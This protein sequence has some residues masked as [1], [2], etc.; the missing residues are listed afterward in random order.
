[1]WRGT[2]RRR[3]GSHDI[4]QSS[5]GIKQIPLS[6]GYSQPDKEA[7][8]AQ[9]E[10]Q[11]CFLAL[12]ASRVYVNQVYF[13]YLCIF[14]YTHTYIHAYVQIY[15]Y[16]DIFWGWG[17]VGVC[18][19]LLLNSSFAAVQQ[20]ESRGSA[21]QLQQMQHLLKVLLAEAMWR[22]YSPPQVAFTL[23]YPQ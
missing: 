14:V 13:T 22:V 12:N 17:G 6:L 11:L 9:S 1:M 4:F 2:G 18:I 21:K 7:D 23:S 10:L 3:I 5:G 15:T 20:A 19:Y 16:M 8:I